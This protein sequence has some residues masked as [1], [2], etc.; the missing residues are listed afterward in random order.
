M[1]G[2]HW[3]FH[4]MH[5][6]VCLE[7]A[8]GCEFPTA[9]ETFERTNAGMGAIVHDQCAVTRQHFVTNA[10]LI[11]FGDLTLDVVDKLLQL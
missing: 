8:F 2:T 3:R 11:R 7:I 9:N 5:T 10:T 4:S 1:Y 6:H